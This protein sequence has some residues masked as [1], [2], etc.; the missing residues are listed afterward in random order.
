MCALDYCPFFASSRSLLGVWSMK[1]FYSCRVK[2]Q[3]I[4]D[5]ALTAYSELKPLR[6]FF[7][8]QSFIPWLFGQNYR[9]RTVEASLVAQLVKYLPA[10]WE[11]WV[12]SL[13]WEDSLEK[14]KATHA[15]ILAWRIPWTLESIRSQVRHDWMTFFHR[16]VDAFS[17]N[18]YPIRWKALDV[19]SFI[20]HTLA[21]TV[22][23]P[24]IMW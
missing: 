1:L 13:G 20:P 8:T 23:C 4:F 5:A 12:W 22:S 24:K 7:P 16:T 17:F 2:F 14:E 19:W 15:S 11:I 6:S 3:W 10:M 21:L 18:C 9:T